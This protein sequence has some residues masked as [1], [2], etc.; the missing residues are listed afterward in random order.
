MTAP[1]TI[2]PPVTSKARIEVAEIQVLLDRTG[3]SPGVIDGHFG[4]N[5]DKGLAAYRQLTGQVLR[6]TDQEGIRKA[7]AESGG[8]A[9]TS[10][11]ISPE[12]AAGPF[13]ASVP[14]SMAKR[15]SST[16]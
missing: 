12:D 5:V 10:Y 3:I 8:D 11:T 16:S 7:L 1:A 2:E 6:S 14:P 13:V 15:P 4:G 9:F